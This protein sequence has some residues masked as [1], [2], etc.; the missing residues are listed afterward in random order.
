MGVVIPFSLSFIEV[1]VEMSTQGKRIG[2][3]VIL[4][5]RFPNE[6]SALL[7]NCAFYWTASENWW[8]EII[9][10]ASDVRSLRQRPVHP[11]HFDVNP[12][13][14]CAEAAAYNLPG[15]ARRAM[16]RRGRSPS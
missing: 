5:G 12:R 11:S 14:V 13:E 6:D 3:A 2:P 16:R 7:W 8:H 15:L 9:A 1:T 10:F 4:I